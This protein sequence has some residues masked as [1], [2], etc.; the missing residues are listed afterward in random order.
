MGKGRPDHTRLAM[1]QG[2]HGVKKVRHQ[3]TAG[4]NCF[5][6]LFIGGFTM[7]KSNNDPRGDQLPNKVQNAVQFRRYGQYRMTP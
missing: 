1:V 7:T 5:R 3:G 4:R 6:R 2:S